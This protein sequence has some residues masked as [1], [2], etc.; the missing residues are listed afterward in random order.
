MI[1]RLERTETHPCNSHGEEMD[2]T[3]ASFYTGSNQSKER[4]TVRIVDNENNSK[5]TGLKINFGNT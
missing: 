5:K 4:V 3:L 2:E 1:K